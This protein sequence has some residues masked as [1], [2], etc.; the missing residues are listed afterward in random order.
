MKRTIEISAIILAAA[1]IAA[2]PRAFAC[3]NYLITKGAS[4]DGSTMITYSADSHRFYGE[5]YFWPAAKYV[6]GTML[7]V[8][9]WDSGKLLGQI[10]Q[11]DE[12]YT[13]IGNMNEYQVAV[14]ETT[15]G[16]R[17]E[18]RDPDAVVDYGSMM[19]IALQ[20]AKTAR[21]ALEIMTSLVAEYGYASSGESF[22]ISDPDEVWILEMIGKGPENRGAVWVAR[23]VPDGYISG[24]ANAARIRRFPLDDP[25]NTLYSPDVITFAREQGYFAGK[26]KEFSFA[27]A[28]APD[29]FGKRRFCDARVWCM[30]KRAAPSRELSADWI[31]GVED[32]D[33]VPLWIKPDRKL[34]AADV[35][36]FMRD[37]FEGTGLDMTKGSGA[38][39]HALP[40]RWRPL[41]W[42]S[43]EAKYFHE[44]AV[45]TQQTA[46]SFVAQ[47]RG[48][49]PRTIGGVLW[50]G[51][52]D[53]YSTV[54]FPVYAGVSG[55]PYNFAEGTGSFHDVDFDAAFWVFNQVSN[56]AYLRYSD[57]IVDIRKVQRELEGR[58]LAEQDDVDEAAMALH[59]RSP[60]LARDYLTAYTGNAGETVVKSWKELSAFLLYKYLDGN[61]KDARGEVTHPGYPES[62]YEEVATA[63]GERLR[64]K[65]MAPEIAREEERK[66]KA[67]E[68]AGAV[69]TLLKARGIPIDDVTRSEIE[70]VEETDE[71]EEL[72]VRA[73]TADS[74]AAVLD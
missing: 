14:G 52:D 33:P 15:W 29:S 21:E 68:L 34:S 37:H 24:H 38:G 11:V 72:L 65:K 8:I 56:F 32:A 39:P 55:V 9:E 63:A 35:M 44:R 27:D 22:S 49:L 31:A 12:T 19:Y 5:L 20:R 18:L 61:V 45:S 66:V 70:K 1:L 13:V 2:G 7:D 50:F 17:P 41:T 48:W 42:E 74:A 53:T 59:S 3:T 36:G 46:F 30:F 47:S 60:R 26:D 54:Y 73:A 71:L 4:V 16:G 51:V 6:P 64:M 67:R 43:G 40:Y 23:R 58:F 10:A 28:Y 62:W 57:M 69:L 25:E